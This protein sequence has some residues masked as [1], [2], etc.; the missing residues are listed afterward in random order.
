MKKI[1]RREKLRKIS[2][3]NKLVYGVAILW[4]VTSMLLLVISGIGSARSGHNQP[5]PNNDRTRKDAYRQLFA[6]VENQATACALFI[7]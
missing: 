2:R 3:L 5:N 7:S 6:R 4:L 1:E